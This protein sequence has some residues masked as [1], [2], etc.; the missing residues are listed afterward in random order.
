MYSVRLR[1]VSLSENANDGG[2]LEGLAGETICPGNLDVGAKIDPEAEKT[3]CFGEPEGSVSPSS[4]KNF[5][6]RSRIEERKRSDFL[7]SR[8]A[9]T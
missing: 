4:L 2:E 9:I 1:W 3:D 7:P 8:T 5:K 6:E